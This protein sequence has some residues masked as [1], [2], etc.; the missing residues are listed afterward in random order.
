MCNVC[1]H[2]SIQRAVVCFGY[3]PVKVEA[4]QT[5]VYTR[6]ATGAR[7]SATQVAA[8]VGN[9]EKKKT[10]ETQDEEAASST[11]DSRI[12]SSVE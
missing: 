8:L 10:H 7:E 11:G 9:K 3:S 5:N 1:M 2:S 12:S 4:I 6:A